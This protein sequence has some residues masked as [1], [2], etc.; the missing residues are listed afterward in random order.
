MK[1]LPPMSVDQARDLI[2][3]S[4]PRPG[5]A[6]TVSLAHALGRVA[7]EDVAAPG[8]QPRFDCAAMDGWVVCGQAG[9]YRVVGESRAGAPYPRAMAQGEAVAIS[10][11]AVVPE[12]AS[13]LV[14]REQGHEDQGQLTIAA[15]RPGRDMRLR[16][17]D[18]RRGDVLVAAGRVVDHLDIARVAASGIDRIAVRPVLRVALLATG[19]EIVPGGG[20]PGPGGAWD[21]LSPAIMA[22][23]DGVQSL[24]VARDA[25]G[26]IAGRVAASDAQVVIVIGGA[27]G[28]RHDRVRHALGELGLAVVVPCVAMRPGKPFWCGHLE[29]GRFVFGLP[30][31]PVAALVALELFVIPALSGGEPQGWID[32]P[33]QDTGE[34]SDRLRFARWSVGA[35]GRI[36]ADALGQGDSASLAPLAG[37][38]G[39]MRIAADGRRR[40]LP[41]GIRAGIGC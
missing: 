19:D 23:I 3:R 16:G 38:N 36:H 15:Y 13:A 25:D 4:M 33:P 21:A 41:L 27:S 1:P 2:L 30:G 20:E 29:G 22:R 12:G 39:L 18:F 40:L 17:C 35:D 11:G 34:G 5:G 26:D 31:N 28:G 7:V 37:A 24:G 14:R 10:T 32:L 6:E 8:D 9:A